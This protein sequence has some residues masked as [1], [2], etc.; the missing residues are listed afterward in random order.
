MEKSLELVRQLV[1]DFRTHENAYLSPT[2]QELEVRH[3][4]ID[5]FFMALGWDVNHERQ[6]NPYEQEVH[7]ENRIRAEGTQRRADYA[8]FTAPNFRDVKYFVEAKK[9]AHDLANPNYYYQTV[10]YG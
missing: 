4:F 8:F 7:M 3:D 5:K 6:K 9:P 2:Y 10:R 1:N